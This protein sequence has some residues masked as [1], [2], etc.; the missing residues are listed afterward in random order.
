MFTC[1]SLSSAHSSQIPLIFPSSNVCF[2]FGG[3]H[4]AAIHWGT[5]TS[6]TLRWIGELVSAECVHIQFDFLFDI[7]QFHSSENHCN[8]W[9]SSW[10]NEACEIFSIGV[11]QQC[12]FTSGQHGL[13]FC[14]LASQQK[15]LCLIPDSDPLCG[16]HVLWVFVVFHPHSRNVQVRWIRVSTLP[17]GMNVRV[18]LL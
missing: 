11:N 15:T 7:K 5:Y 13:V 18:Y 6:S 2:Q 8:R 14:T 4:H 3:S 9:L 16:L 10:Y 17:V 12:F 1:C